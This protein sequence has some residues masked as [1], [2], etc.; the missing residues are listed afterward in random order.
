MLTRH[1]FAE[2]LYEQEAR[3]FEEVEGRPPV[4]SDITK[5]SVLAVVMNELGMLDE[6][7]ELKRYAEERSGVLYHWVQSDP[8]DQAMLTVREMLDL[9]PSK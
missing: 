7:P 2:Y 1:Q 6:H 9:L 4:P 3:G 5:S 8:F